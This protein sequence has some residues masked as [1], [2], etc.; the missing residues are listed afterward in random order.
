MYKYN[1]LKRLDQLSINDREIFWTWA[2]EQLRRDKDTIRGWCYI[3]HDE[4]RE[5]GVTLLLKLSVF[6]QCSII[7]LINYPENR[8]DITN[9]IKSH[10]HVHSRNNTDTE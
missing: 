9:S 8:E 2:P 3:K 6:F 10:Y 7:D 4:P 5:I 1:L